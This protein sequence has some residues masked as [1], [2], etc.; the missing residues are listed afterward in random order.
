MI[1]GMQDRIGIEHARGRVDAAGNHGMTGSGDR[2]PRARDIRPGAGS[3]L[4]E[5]SP[6]SRI[7]RDSTLLN[8]VP[9]RAY[10]KTMNG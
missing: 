2:V 10:R 7:W 9:L 8:L 3:L 4:R 1:D 6:G 5:G